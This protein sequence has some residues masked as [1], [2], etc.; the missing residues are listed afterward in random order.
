MAHYCLP[1][2][3]FIS[4]LLGGFLAE[5]VGIP[6]AWV[7]GP[8]VVTAVFSISGTKPFAPLSG[9]RLGQLIIGCAI[10]LNVTPALA[11]SVTGLIPAMVISA[12]VAML[13]GASIAIGLAHFS[14]VDTKTAYYC[15]MPGGLSEMANVGAEY[16][17]QHEPI[18]V[19][20]AIR[21][22]LVV[23]LLPPLMVGLDWHGS[24]SG[25][26]S[27]HV[28]TIDRIPFV[29]F[30]AL[31]GVLVLY[32]LRLNN[33]WMV[34]SLIGVGIASGF[35]LFDGRL[36]REIF[37]AGQFLLGISIGS[38]FRR[39]AILALG[40]FTLASGFCTI[41]ITTLLFG[42]GILL[43]NVTKFDIASAILSVSPGGFAEMAVTAELLSLNI[44]AVTAFHVVRAS[45]VNSL[46]THYYNLLFRIGFFS[47]GHALLR[48]FFKQSHAGK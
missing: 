33:P 25:Q 8:L 41:I 24:F 1:I 23:C 6:L 45:L 39:D 36:S 20:Q 31:I 30:I 48:K 34:G 44:A 40:T 47:A 16:G 19:S 27:A 5:K 43:S 21:V 2:L 7:L 9:R 11:A 12:F 28:L 26:L 17:A 13:V 46:T 32:H 3:C 22:A 15:M 42:Y 37:F 38:R 29:V 14:R 10:G 18:A 4:A 35:G